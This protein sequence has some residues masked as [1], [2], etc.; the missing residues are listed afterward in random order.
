M[1]NLAERNV[2]NF[3]KETRHLPEMVPWDLSGQSVEIDV[4]FSPFT[5]TLDH[6]LINSLLYNLIF[7]ISLFGSH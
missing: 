6:L 2:P 5:E 7:S 1:R 3:A 4:T